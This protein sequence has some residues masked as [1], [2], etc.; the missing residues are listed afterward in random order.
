MG[1]VLLVGALAGGCG[2]EVAEA[3]C[4]GPAACATLRLSAPELG[5]VTLDQLEVVVRVGDR[6]RR[7]FVRDQVLRLPMVVPL[8]M[9]EMESGAGGARAALYLRGTWEG[10]ASPAWLSGALEWVGE[11]RPDREIAL[12]P[13][14]DGGCVSP[15]GR[16]G[17]AMAYDPASRRL[18]LFGGDGG[19]G[20]LGD[21]WEWDG[22]AW[23]PLRPA[24]SPPARAG[25]AMSFDPQ[26]G[27]PILFGGVG[28][29]GQVLGDLWEYLGA[30]AGWRL[31]DAAGPAPRSLAAMAPAPISG[32]E[33]GAVPGVLLFGGLGADG[34]PLGDS[35]TWDG[36][37]FTH[38]GATPCDGADVTAPRTPACRAGAALGL[39]DLQARGGRGALLI[40]GL[41]S[42]GALGDRYDDRVWRWDGASW[43]QAQVQSPPTVLRRAGHRLVPTGDGQLLVLGGLSD[44]VLR[45]DAYL[46]DPARGLFVPQ[47]GAAPQARA[48]AAAAFDEERGE[49]VVAGGRGQ[50]GVL[51]DTWLFSASGAESGGWTAAR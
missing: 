36:R 24:A 16:Q 6:H 5:P 3:T 44:G 23:R 50:G 8:P 27:R 46:I 42:R 38:R 9:P 20:V 7:L 26:R 30:E 33:G 15:E 14:C 13:A 10:G 41:L 1:S 29:G 43:F 47:L 34:A 48:A 28:A 18:V 21:S 4:A 11:R 32:P 35:W 22:G 31:I 39:A 2:G 19:A 12:R 49:V 45:Q 17:A 51:A 25:H 37:A 40:G